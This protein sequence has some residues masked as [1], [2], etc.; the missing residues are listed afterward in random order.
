M[1]VPAIWPIPGN[2][3]TRARVSSVLINR[4]SDGSPWVT[5]NIN[6]ATDVGTSTFEKS[7]PDLTINLPLAGLLVDPDLGPTV[8]SIAQNLE[9]VAYTLYVRRTTPPPAPIVPPQP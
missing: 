9:L 4:P 3:G 5:F 7:R 6:E 2:T 1:D 8:A